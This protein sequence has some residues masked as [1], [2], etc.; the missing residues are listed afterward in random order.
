MQAFLKKIN[1]SLS[2]IFKHNTV[3]NKASSHL[4]ISANAKRVRPLLTAYFANA[5][6]IPIESIFQ[7]AITSELIHSASLLHDDVIDEGKI[8]RGIPTVNSQWSNS[9]AILSGNYLL[10]KA[11]EQLKQFPP[12]ITQEAISVIKDMT[13]G[14]M[15]E[16]SMRNYSNCNLNN[17]RSMV[18]GKTGSLFSFCGTSVA[19]YCG[20]LEAVISFK[21]IGQHIGQIFQLIDELQDIFE[22]SENSESTYMNLMISTGHKDPVL[23]CKMEL[24]KQ[25]QSVTEL[26]DPWKSTLGGKQIILWLKNISNFSTL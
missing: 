24:L 19:L 21:I 20:N 23:S 7:L 2:S 25:I 6:N 1:F 11:F 17:W 15:L 10:V 4:C 14:A 12:T 22:D 8:R 18:I 26:I 5:L 9:I 13:E 3:L 16:I